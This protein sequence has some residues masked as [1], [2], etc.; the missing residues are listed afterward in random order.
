MW[1]LI[2]W[3]YAPTFVA[4]G[5]LYSFDSSATR[6]ASVSTAKSARF[7]P[8]SAEFFGCHSGAAGA[9]TS[10]TR[11]EVSFAGFVGVLADRAR[12]DLR[13]DDGLA[14]GWGRGVILRGESAIMRKILFDFFGFGQRGSGAPRMR[15]ALQYR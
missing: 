8:L 6:I 1:S 15:C 7:L 9:A 11:F 13:L 4:S 2:S 3:L 14:G 5:S 10:V 12:G